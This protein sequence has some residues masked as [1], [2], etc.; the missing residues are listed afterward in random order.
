MKINPITTPINF[1]K[2]FITNATILKNGRNYECDIFEINPIKDYDYFIQLKQDKNWKDALFLDE[3]E[4]WFS[5]SFLGQR[6]YTIENKEKECLGFVHIDCEDSKKIEINL[7]EVCPKYANKNKQ[8]EAKYI[9]TAL[10]NFLIN[11]AKGEKK[12]EITVPTVYPPS[13]D[14]Y[15]KCGFANL[16]VPKEYAKLTSNKFDDALEQNKS[17]NES[18]CKKSDR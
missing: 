12:E 3:G 13:I 2:K 4:E 18:Q 6:T 11:L 9:G 7:L 5:Y 15:K 14:F 16:L 10:I 1:Q 8:R 17:C